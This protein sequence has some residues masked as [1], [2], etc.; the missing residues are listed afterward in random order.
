MSVFASRTR[1]EVTYE[2]LT[3]VIRKLSGASLEKA[4]EQRAIVAM[5]ITANAGADALRQAR[6]NSRDQKEKPAD[7]A[8]PE[9]PKPVNP[10]DRHNGYDRET[11]LIAGIHSWNAADENGKLLPV[12]PDNVLDLTEGACDFLFHEIL[13]LSLPSLNVTAIEADQKKD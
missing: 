6:E 12:T 4:G 10:R 1:K 3:A 11:V 5:R 2:D 13:D 8:A 9:A 7:G